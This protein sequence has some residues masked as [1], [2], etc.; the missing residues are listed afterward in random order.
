MTRVWRGAVYRITVE[1]PGGVE[2]GVARISCNG[3]PVEGLI[4]VQ[5]AGSVNRVTVVMGPA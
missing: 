1:N 5:P 3:L 4:P 2:K